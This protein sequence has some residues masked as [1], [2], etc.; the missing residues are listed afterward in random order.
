[1]VL[2]NEFNLQLNQQLNQT[3]TFKNSS[4]LSNKT[5]ILVETVCLT[6]NVYA[7]FKPSMK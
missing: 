2:K 5:S 6:G 4:L 1:M 3:N 7:A